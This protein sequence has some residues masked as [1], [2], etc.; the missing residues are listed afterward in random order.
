M[1]CFSLFGTESVE[2]KFFLLRLSSVLMVQTCFVPDEYWQSLEVAHHLSFGY[3]YLT[4]EWFE[5]IRSLIHP[6]VIALVYKHLENVRLDTPLNLVRQ[7]IL[8]LTIH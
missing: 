3:G 5:G 4:W 8:I 6:L 7:I 2:V 1:D